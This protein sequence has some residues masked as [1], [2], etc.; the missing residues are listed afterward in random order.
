MKFPPNFTRHILKMFKK[1]SSMD[2]EKR[3]DTT[4]LLLR[5]VL[6]FVLAPILN[7]VVSFLFSVSMLL[8]FLKSLNVC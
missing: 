6:I 8:P 4:T 2:T 3:K 7:V 1:G 5:D